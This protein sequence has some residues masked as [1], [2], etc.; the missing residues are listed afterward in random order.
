M[1]LTMIRK[2]TQTA[3]TKVAELLAEVNDELN[4]CQAVLD[5]GLVQL[6][7]EDEALLRSRMVTLQHE[8]QALHLTLRQ[9]DPDIDPHCIGTS[10]CWFKTRCRTAKCEHAAYLAAMNGRRAS[11]PN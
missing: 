6:S 7:G 3:L 8:R 1:A 4:L 9:F 2:R 5:Q 11:P 10:R